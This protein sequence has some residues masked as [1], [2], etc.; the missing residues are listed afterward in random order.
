MLKI[1]EPREDTNNRKGK[2][3][4]IDCGPDLSGWTGRR[5]LADLLEAFGAYIDYA[6]IATLN[7][8]ILP[9]PFLQ[10]TIRQYREANVETFAGGLLFEYAYLKNEVPELI[11]LL[12][13]LGL[14]GIE[15]SENYIT[16][17]KDERNFQ[18]EQLGKAGLNVVFEYGEN[19]PETP[20]S[21]E[22]LDRVIKEVSDLGV[23]H[24]VVEQGEC[25]L[26]AA[27]RPDELEAMKAQS[28]MDDVF[29]EVETGEFPKPQIELIKQ[30]G[31][32]ANIANVAPAHVYKLEMLRRG[33][34]R[35]IDYPFFR[36]LVAQRNAERKVD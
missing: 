13:H 7:A 5:G 34:G 3:L 35:W 16:L 11:E 26:L 20:L 9:K 19:Y 22:D 36:D 8:A 28:W 23:K 27:E 10:E 32:E 2:T 4:I 30:F 21:V 12:K 17:N 1:D 18:I 15:V 6:K 29:I 25:E 33:R 14:G 31:P 24:V